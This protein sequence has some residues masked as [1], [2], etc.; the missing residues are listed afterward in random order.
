[1]SGKMQNEY[2]KMEIP[3]KDIF[4]IE[5]MDERMAEAEWYLMW[6]YCHA[7]SLAEE[8]WEDNY[9][10]EYMVALAQKVGRPYD[11][12]TM[13]FKRKGERIDK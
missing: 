4:E 11:P 6:G 2:L 12:K 13:E 1:M 8:W 3:V 7:N 10:G 5:K 9:F